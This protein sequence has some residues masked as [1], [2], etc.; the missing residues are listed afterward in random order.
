M[1]P[2]ALALGILLLTACGGP[3]PVPAASPEAGGYPTGHIHGMSIDKTTKRILLAT[4]DGL[5]DVSASP[6]QQI[7]PTLD[8]MGFTAAPDGTFYASGHPAP[9]T[10][11]P[12]PMGLIRSMDA[13]Q[14][15]VPA[16]LMGESDLH[17]LTATQD[18]LVAFDG[19]VKTSGDG[20]EWQ[21]S[22][23]GIQPFSLAGSPVDATVLATTEKGL[24]RST[25]GGQTWNAVDGAPLLLLASITG[26][27]AAGVTP[28]GR[29]YVSV[30]A[31]STWSERGTLEEPVVALTA[32]PARHGVPEIWVA[33]QTGVSAS[34]DGGRTFNR[35]TP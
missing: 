6:V 29:V 18:A 30:D 25:D 17:A 35:V 21:D 16:S 1:R 28:E 19:Q 27:A 4:H 26:Q 20:T 33:T 23:T 24:Q 22:G 3:D 31:G 9:G 2:A 8:L 34:T 11:F 7:G 12:D 13:G 14:T 10:D 32:L 5:F 15:W